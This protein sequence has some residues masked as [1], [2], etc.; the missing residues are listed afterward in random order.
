MIVVTEKKTRRQQYT[1]YYECELYT[2]R[3][4]C[5]DGSKV[6]DPRLQ[7]ASCQKGDCRSK[8]LKGHLKQ[9]ETCIYF[10]CFLTEFPDEI[11][12]VSLL[13]DWLAQRVITTPLEMDRQH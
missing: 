6:D 3:T 2:V 9:R 13:L 8:I 11:W 1:L 4:E 5:Y 10:Q 7:P 12:R